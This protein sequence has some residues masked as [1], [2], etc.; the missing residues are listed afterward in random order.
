MVILMS[1]STQK[2]REQLIDD[3][4]RY[5]KPIFNYYPSKQDRRRIERIV[6]AQK[7]VKEGNYYNNSRESEGLTCMDMVIRS[8][9]VDKAKNRADSTAE[10]IFLETLQRHKLKFRFQ[11]KIG[12]YRADFLIG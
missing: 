7:I 4:Y 3:L 9:D 12:K 1:E 2:L 8:M 5:L 11:Y 10:L 6:N